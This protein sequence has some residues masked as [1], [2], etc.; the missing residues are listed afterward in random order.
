[1]ADL[2]FLASRL[3]AFRESRAHER[4]LKQTVPFYIV[5]IQVVTIHTHAP[6]FFGNN[7]NYVPLRWEIMIPTDVTLGYPGLKIFGAIPAGLTSD[8][9]TDPLSP[10]NADANGYI[11]QQ[12]FNAWG[13]NLLGGI[14]PLDLQGLFGTGDQGPLA[15]RGIL[16][17][18]PS[19]GFDVSYFG[20]VQPFPGELGGSPLSDGSGGVPSVGAPWNAFMGALHQSLPYRARTDI[21]IEFDLLVPR[22]S[23]V[24]SSDL[25]FTGDIDIITTS[26]FYQDSLAVVADP[27]TRDYYEGFVGMD[28]FVVGEPHQ[29]LIDGDFNYDVYRVVARIVDRLVKR[30]PVVQLVCTVSGALVVGSKVS[31]E[32]TF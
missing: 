14:Y 20:L 11:W 19:V 12:P 22:G 2:D 4:R 27:A 5:G 24:L 31:L 25:I 28:P 32:L 7:W 16:H 26:D 30:N 6:D 8:P 29:V 1:M 3:G 23:T 18:F 9:L 15:I 13:D 21:A 17:T 10:Y